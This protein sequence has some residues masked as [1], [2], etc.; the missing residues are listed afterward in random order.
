MV[1]NGSEDHQKRHLH[2]HRRWFHQCCLSGISWQEDTGHGCP[3]AL[4][5]ALLRST[6]SPCCQELPQG[7]REPSVQEPTSR[8]G[9]S[10]HLGRC[11]SA[12]D[13]LWWQLQRGMAVTV[14]GPAQLYPCGA[15]QQ[16][17]HQSRAQPSSKQSLCPA[18]TATLSLCLLP[19]PPRGSPARAAQ[20]LL[21]RAC[22]LRLCPLPPAL[23][24][25]VPCQDCSPACRVVQC[26]SV[27]SSPYGRSCCILLCCLFG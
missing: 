26:T 12:G 18:S 1:Q 4:P 13:P 10:G 15:Q 3:C 9:C 16:W 14:P 5:S 24:P 2:A 17:G 20:P 8:Q 6:P 7:C 21:L 25:A 23:L 19:E 11:L 27:A 22:L